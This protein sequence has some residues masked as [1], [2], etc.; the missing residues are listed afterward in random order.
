MVKILVVE[1]FRSLRALYKRDLELDGYEVISASTPTEA[2][3]LLEKESPQLVVLDTRASGMEAL[4][5]V[6]KLLDRDPRIPVVL[7]SGSSSC[8]DYPPGRVADA[9]VVKSSDTGELRSKIRDLL[10][11]GRTGVV[12]TFPTR[13]SDDNR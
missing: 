7:N 3:E 12:K 8:A 2:L 9:F 11:G 10:K 4:E 5:T 6:I 1:G 13:R